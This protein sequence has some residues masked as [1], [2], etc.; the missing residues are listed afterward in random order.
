[1]IPKLAGARPCG[2]LVLV[3]LLTRNELLGTEIHIPG[4]ETTDVI[5]QAYV[6][7]TGPSLKSEDYG[8]KVGDR[9]MLVGKG[10]NPLPE[11]KEERQRKLNLVE[12]NVIRCVLIEDDTPKDE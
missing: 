6:L 10:A 12:P 11:F 7:D 4:T 9:V 8:F 1:M 3:E 2:S 5:Q